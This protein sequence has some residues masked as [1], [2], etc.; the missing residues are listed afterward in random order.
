MIRVIGV[1]QRY[2]HDD[3]VG[4]VVAERLAESVDSST[5]N[6]VTA[7]GEGTDLMDRWRGAGTVVIVDAVASEADP[8]GTIYR[9]QA[10][11][12]PIP[13]EI[14]PQSTH[15]F[16]LPQAIELARVFGELPP[17]LIVFGVVGADFHM[18][19]GLSASVADSIDDVVRRI[20]ADVGDAVQVGERHA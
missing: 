15:L 9:W 11:D 14:F 4:L 13:A 7:S 17:R 18:G 2:R 19:E 20:E 10:H 16:S 6:V 5:V 1:G 8:P 12:T 3:A